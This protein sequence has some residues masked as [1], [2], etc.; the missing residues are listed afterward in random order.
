M[1]L[2]RR[3]YYYKAKEQSS[4]EALKTRIGDI[5][6]EFSGYGYRRVTR[7]LNREGLIV[8]HKKVSRIMRENGWSC[9]LRK[10][11]WVTTTNS[12]HGF[13][14]YPNLIKGLNISAINQVWMADITY[15]HILASFVYLAVILDAFSRKAIGYSLSRNI[16]TRL[17][18]D[19]LRMALHNRQPKSG[20]IHHSDRGVQYASCDYVKELKSYDFQISMSRKGNPYDNA[21][22]ESFIKT[23]KSEEVQLWEY[24]TMEDVQNRIP[25]FIE[26]V[27]NQKRLH[28]SLGYRP[29]CEFET[30]VMLNQNTCQNTLITSL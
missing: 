16:D 17:T 5:C 27:Y 1:K 10:K 13:H 4:D 3:S 30:M 20:C 9:S 21:Y 22:A 6:L 8:N 26:D 25:Y 12:N 14:I 28:S 18:L 11:R 29:P 23:L 2:P 15:I 19:A 7:Q 24:R